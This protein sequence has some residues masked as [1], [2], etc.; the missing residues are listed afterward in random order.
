MQTK[1]IM[2]Q[3]TGSGVGKSVLV[4]ALCRIFKQDGYNVAPFKAQ[5]MALNCGVTKDGKEMGRAQITQAQACKIEPEVEMNPILIKPTSNTKAQIILLG[6]PI[7]NMDAQTYHKYKPKLRQTIIKSLNKLKSKY[8]IVVI[9]GAGSPA[10]IN[11][12]EHDLVNMNL[13]QISNSPVILVAD[14][15]KGG[16]F[17]WIVGTLELLN[18]QE[19]ERI[20]GIIINKFRGDE[21]LIKSG[22]DFIQKRCKKPVLGI[23]PYFKD[24]KIDEEDSVCLE[25]QNAIY[26]MQ[27]AKLSIAVIHLPHISNFTD[28]DVLEKEKDV[29]LR[30]IKSRDFLG[31]PDLIIIPGTKNTIDDLHYIKEIGLADQIIASSAIIIGICGGYQMLGRKIQDPYQIESDKKQITGLGLLDITTTIEK[32]KATFQVKAIAET[33]IFNIE[34]LKIEGYEIHAGNTSLLQ[35]TQPLFRII[36]R[37]TQDVNILDGAISKDSKVIGTYIHGI[38]DNDSF[39]Y[40]LL[41]YLRNRKGLPLI[42]QLDRFNANKIKEEEYDKLANLIREKLDMKKIYDI[43]EGVNV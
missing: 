43:L 37:G 23:I 13:A 5:N 27:D 10:E 29:E 3:G 14:I 31:N 17:A 19:K 16:V 39:R 8:E 28:F 33:N 11:L 36:K 20:K 15:D 6:K 2:I 18:K 42:S 21:Q 24:I 35:H 1:T 26:K 25:M 4:T 41:D 38:F 30:Y 7:G 22:I 34:N 12:K 40:A 32:T 9:E